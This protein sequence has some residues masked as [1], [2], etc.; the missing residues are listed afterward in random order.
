MVIFLLLFAMATS[1]VYLWYENNVQYINT[2]QVETAIT[3]GQIGQN[4]VISPINNTLISI[5]NPTSQA[6]VVAQVWSN[7]TEIWKGAQGAPPFSTVQITL[8]SSSQTNGAFTVVT[9]VG[10]LFYGGGAVELNDA[11]IR[12]WD[13]TLINIV[14]A[15]QYPLNLTYSPN[16]INGTIYLNDLGF[17]W[18]WT[19]T[20]PIG[21]VANATIMK[22][23]P[24]GSLASINF[25]VDQNSDIQVAIDGNMNNYWSNWT[26]YLSYTISGPQ[27]S[28]HTITIYY[29]YGGVLPPVLK[30]NIENATFVPDSSFLP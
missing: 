11:S 24:N 3:N 4:L 14:T 2:L 21:L 15:P 29:Y 18:K 1:Y 8:N 16:T 19:S 5:T 12:Y 7:H 9:S 6:V 27:Y 17:M 28:I 26:N 20:T 25:Y 10:N 30:L 13:G 22:T 23:S